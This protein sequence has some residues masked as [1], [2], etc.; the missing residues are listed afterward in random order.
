MTI[1]QL[2]HTWFARI[3]QLWPT[4]RITRLRNLAW[5]LVGVF[6]SRSVQLPKIAEHIPGAATQPSLIRRLSRFLDNEAVQVRKWY[7][8]VARS[9]LEAMA[10]STGE[11][12]LIA[13]ASKVSFHHQQLMIAVAF[14]RRAL[15]IAWTWIPSARGRSSSHKQLALLAY[16][17][18]LLPKGVPVLLVGDNEFGAVEVIRQLEAWHW[19]YVLR[20]KGKTQA[21]LD[22]QIEWPHLRDLVKEGQDRWLGPA[23]LTAAHAHPVYLWVYW[24]RGEEEPWLLATNLPT[25]AQTQPAYRRRMWIEE[26]FGDLKGHGFDWEHTH[27]IHFARLSRMALVAALLYDWLISTGVRVVRQGRRFWVDRVDRRDLSFFQIGWRWIRRCITNNLPFTVELVPAVAG[28]LSG[29]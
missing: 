11:I 18:R 9:L 1:N 13:D 25:K 16:V 3:Q 15:P 29:G 7:E 8:P 6:L 17:Q 12:R 27:L 2:Y 21:Q 10:R 26:L 14:R 24:R 22:G 19:S 5:L 28:K 4:E 23:R 20:Q